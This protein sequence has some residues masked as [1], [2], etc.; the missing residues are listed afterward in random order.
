MRNRM[1]ISIYEGNTYDSTVI[2][3]KYYK[4]AFPEEERIPP[5]KMIRLIG[6]GVYHLLVGCFSDSGTAFGYAFLCNSPDGKSVLL[7]YFFILP[8]YRGKGYGEMF[9]KGLKERAK[10]Q[11]LIFEVEKSE[12]PDDLKAHRIR[13]YLRS[14]A[15][16]LPFPYLFPTRTGELPMHLMTLSEMPEGGYD[17]VRLRKF[18]SYAMELLHSDTDY[19]TVLS[20]YLNGIPDKILV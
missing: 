8:E 4:E 6:Y 5:E 12:A 15:V 18:L 14:G 7:D 2:L 3:G 10:G 17:G 9:L 16:I 13:F 20:H 1:N 11:M 19:K